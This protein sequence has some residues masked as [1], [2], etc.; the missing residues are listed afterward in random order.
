MPLMARHTRPIDQEIGARVRVRRKQLGINQA[1]LG[2]RLD[3][4]FQ[5]MQKYERGANRISASSLVVLAEALK[6]R[7]ADLLGVEDTATAIDWTQFHENDAQDA[8]T[9]FTA[10][11]SPRQR[12]AVLDLMRAMAQRDGS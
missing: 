5:Q 12:R 3:V 8:L 4:S 9:A 10:I 1:E 2:E 11:K 6:C 7:P